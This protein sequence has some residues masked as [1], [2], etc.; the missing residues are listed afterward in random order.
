MPIGSFEKVMP[1]DVLPTQLLRSIVVGDTDM[2]QKLGCLELDEED[3]ALCSFVCSG[4]YDYAPVL[5]NNLT[6]I[7]REG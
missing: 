1:L 4:K 3:L 5:R 6:Q 2:A 7:E